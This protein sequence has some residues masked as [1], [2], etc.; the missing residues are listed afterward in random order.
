MASISKAFMVSSMM[1][2]GAMAAP[3]ADL[4]DQIPDFPKAS[5]K[6]YSGY[7]DVPGPFKQNDY[8]SLKIHYQFHESMNS[9]SSDPV[10]TWH[11]G[12]PGGSSIYGQ[13]GEMG[14]FQVDDNGTAI[15]PFSWNRVANMLYLES[16]AGSSDPIGFSSCTKDGR[17]AAVCSWNDTSQAEAYAH[18]LQAFYKAFPE[19]ASNDLYISGES[20]AG[21]YIPNIAYYIVNNF[22]SSIKLKGILVGNGCWGGTSTQVECN[23]PNSEQ[24]D[25]DMYFG[26]GLVS[27]ITYEKVYKECTFPLTGRP[28]AACDLALETA[29]QEVGPHNVYDIY[30]NCPQTEKWLQQSGKSMRW[31]KNYLRARMNT[32]NAADIDRELGLLGGGYKWNCGGL[33]DLSNFLSRTDVRQ[34]LHLDAPNPSRFDYSSSGP[35]SITL[36]PHLV[37]KMRV[38][39]YN[40]DSDAC[41]PYKGN[42]EWTEGLAAQGVINKKKAWHPWYDAAAPAHIPAGYATTYTVPQSENDF[43]FVTIRLAGHMVPQFQPSSALAFFQ[44]FLA[45]TPF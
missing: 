14:Y 29:S 16:P 28:T 9:P 21:Q 44:Q 22:A 24:N 5:F 3:T 2:V 8:D 37:T 27:K 15:N 30:D 45:G 11:Q 7:L 40:G 36:Y 34:A 13:Y 42:E 18:T 12:G 26:K 43:S 23:G 35:A 41:V 39:I 4:V 17:V 6:V 32:G 25:V 10:V 33:D 1:A 38:L 20:Y 19:F 31:L